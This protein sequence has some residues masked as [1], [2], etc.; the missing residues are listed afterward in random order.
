MYKNFFKR[1]ID[2]VISFTL[3]LLLLPLYIIV[4]FA[5][6]IDMGTPVIF[7]QVRIGENEKPFT[8]YKFRS[9]KVTNNS[10]GNIH[11]DR[12]R[13]TKLGVFIRSTSLDELPELFNVLLGDMTIVGPRPFPDYYMPFYSNEERRRHSL[14]GGLI[15]CDGLLGRSDVTWEEQF[16][17]ELYYVDNVSFSLDM[18]IIFKTFSILLQRAESDYGNIERPLLN[19]VRKKRNDY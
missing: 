14:K 3:I 11:D 15:P 17:A 9:M 13:L 8:M 10:I 16:K 4:G 12:S 5:I 19:E 2:V 18:K 1:L 6:L 7:K